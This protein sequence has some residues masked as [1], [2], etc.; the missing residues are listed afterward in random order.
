[1]EHVVIG[2][3][4]ADH[5]IRVLVIALVPVNVVNRC[6]YRQTLTERSLCHHHVFTNKAAPSVIS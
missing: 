3:V 5:K 1:M 2:V 6:A 4:L